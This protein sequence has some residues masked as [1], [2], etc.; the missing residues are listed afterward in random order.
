MMLLK[1]MIMSIIFDMLLL[2]SGEEGV[3]V[4]QGFPVLIVLFCQFSS[5][6]PSALPSCS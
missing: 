1:I 6:C 2:Y 4:Y 3:S 5:V